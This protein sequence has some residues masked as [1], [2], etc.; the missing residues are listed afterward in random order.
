MGKIVYS[1]IANFIPGVN[2]SRIESENQ[3]K[4]IASIQHSCIRLMIG[5]LK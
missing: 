3:V 2:L 5:N 4:S 1:D